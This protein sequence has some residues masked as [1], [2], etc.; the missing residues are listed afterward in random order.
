MKKDLWLVNASP[1]PRA[2]RMYCFCYAGGNAL[3]FLEWQGRI[4]ANIEIC[5]FQL[6]GR[7]ARFHEAPM[8]KFDELIVAL[9]EV[10]QKQGNMPFAFFGHSLGGLVAFELARYLSRKGLPT[11]RHL[12]LSGCHAPRYRSTPEALHLLDD[13]A[14]LEKL[15]ELNG[16]PTEILEHAELMKMLLPT[17]RADMALV[18]DYVYRTGPPLA[19]PVTVFAGRDDDHDGPEQCAGWGEETSAGC[20]VQWFAGDHFFIN[21]ANEEV[22]ACLNRTLSGYLPLVRSQQLLARHI[23]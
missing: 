4:D 5:A 22:L 13:G 20:A 17:I 3:G 15:R 14:L 9:A 12:V 2:F 18:H 16:T 8:T 6:P 7:G 23:Y 11:P 19:I 1:Q 10:M 21:S